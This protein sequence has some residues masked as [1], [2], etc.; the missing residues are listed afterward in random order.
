MDTALLRMLLFV[1]V[2]LGIA[3]L[4]RKPAR[5]LFGAGPAFT[6]WCLP[7]TL[8]A[9][10]W[11]PASP[12][13]WAILPPI[14]VLAFTQPAITT[15]AGDHPWHNVLL[16]LWL[17][18]A[19]AGGLRLIVHYLRLC[20]DTRPLPPDMRRHLPADLS[21]R[22]ARRLRLHPSG[23]AVL[24]APRA[25]VLLPEDFHERFDMAERQL[26]LRHELGHVHR[27]DPL[28]SLLAELVAALL[29]FHPL[30]WLS[31]P[32]FRL[33]QEL[34]C[35]EHV[36]RDAPC[37][38]AGYAHTLLHSL[39][40]SPV[41]AL[42]PWFAKPQLKERLTM[43]QRHRPSSLRRRFGY[44]VLAMLMAGGVFVVQAATGTQVN[45]K[46]SENPTIQPRYPA[47]A[48]KAKEQGTVVLDVQVLA[49]GSIGTITYDAKQS[50]T[51]SVALIW[52][53]TTIA[54]QSHFN[55]QMKDGKLVDG[56]TRLPVKFDLSPL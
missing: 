25:H 23:P 17:L 4:L 5:R 49:D 28:W 8:A 32:R 10:P 15:T 41:S 14:H 3:L 38:A 31:L 34:A 47:A 13:G 52:A 56:Y 22:D 36:L 26:V 19:A 20:R 50:T 2:G 40:L 44:A 35:D 51:S 9:M 7:I 43:I 6:L 18:G 55:P 12:H 24:W 37:D 46:A 54:R 30:A 45:P 11:L 33:D 39:G 29:W 21:E 27:G 16:A 53:A 1:T 42:V 48:I